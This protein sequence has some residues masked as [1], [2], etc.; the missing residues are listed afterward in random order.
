MPPTPLFRLYK[1]WVHEG[2]IA[3]PLICYWPARIRQG[4]AIT[5]ELGHVIDL[6]ATCLD[7]AGVPYPESYREKPIKPIEGK[8]LRPI[9]ETG[10]REGHQA[11]FWEHEGN[12]AVRKGP[13]KLVSRF[14]GS[15]DVHGDWELYD[16][17]A[18]RSEMNDLASHNRERVAEMTA[19]YDE[20]AGRAEVVPWNRLTTA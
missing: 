3:S 11:I 6:S 10:N 2:G 5:N 12:R 9:F 17:E 7:V 18:D 13:W 19:L 14:R 16:L 20:W 1:H 4:G 15:G 8:S